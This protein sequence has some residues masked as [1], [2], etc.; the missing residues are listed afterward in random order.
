MSEDTFARF[1]HSL[2]ARKLEKDKNLR[3]ESKRYWEIILNGSYDFDRS[4]SLAS[5][6]IDGRLSCLEVLFHIH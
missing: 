4:R 6:S 1:V 2:I 5:I 3:Q